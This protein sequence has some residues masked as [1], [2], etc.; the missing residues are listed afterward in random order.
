MARGY[1][2]ST[3]QIAS[4]VGLSQPGLIQRFGSKQDLFL[5]AMTPEPLDIEWIVNGDEAGVDAILAGIA[6][7][8]FEQI[9]ERVPLIL[10]LSQNPDIDEQAIEEAHARIGVPELIDTLCVRIEALAQDGATEKSSKT[11]Q[12][13]EALL[14][15]AH[16][17]TLM[18][19]A[20]APRKGI[21]QHLASFCRLI[22]SG[23]DQETSL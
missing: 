18:S 6:E 15:A 8:L 13:V 1:G 5:A 16:G 12:T 23:H 14:L 4:E 22:P 9:R 7:R 21:K 3:R 11:Q 10:L 19:L 2:A 20:G 17:A